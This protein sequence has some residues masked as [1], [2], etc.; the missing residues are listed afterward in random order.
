MRPFDFSR[1]SDLRD[2]AA[3][4]REGARPIAGG[5]NLLD[6]MKLEVETPAALVDI[7]RLPL[8]RIEA[9]DG[10]LR[11]GALVTNSDCAAD[12]RIRRDYPL[13]ARAILAGAT[14][15]LAMYIGK[16]QGTIKPTTPI[17]SFSVRSRPGFATGIVWP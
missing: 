8:A 9:E 15:Q 13:L 12:P 7:S 11:I 16:F 10:G 14:F 6:L 4:I 2:A 5:T 17:G 1:A 3:R